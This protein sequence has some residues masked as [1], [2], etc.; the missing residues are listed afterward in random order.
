MAC[1][2]QLCFNFYLLTLNLLFQQLFHAHSPYVVCQGLDKVDNMLWFHPTILPS[3]KLQALKSHSLKFQDCGQLSRVKYL[4]YLRYLSMSRKKPE[5]IS[6]Y[7]K[8]LPFDKLVHIASPIDKHS[9][10]PFHFSN[11]FV[12]FLVISKFFCSYLVD[13]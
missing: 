10:S 9:K 3:I 2:H 5:D 13:C 1:A 4:K 12:A 6:D 7:F 11:S 8:M